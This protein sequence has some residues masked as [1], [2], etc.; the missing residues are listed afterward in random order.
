MP[1]IVSAE[2]CVPCTACLNACPEDV[3]FGS[4]GKDLPV[5]SFPDECYLCAACVVDCPTEAITLFIPLSVR[6]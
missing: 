3:F 2:K 1:P 4:T 6:L 5:I